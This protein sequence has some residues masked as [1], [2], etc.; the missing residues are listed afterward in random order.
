MTFRSRLTVAA[1]AAVAVAIVL[2]A[3]AIYVVVRN[4]LLGTVD[5]ALRGSV[6]RVVRVDPFGARVVE[7]PRVS[8]SV[9]FTEQ[10]VLAQLVR[11]DGVAVAST[12]RLSLPVTGRAREVASGESD[13]YFSDATLDGVHVRVY[14]A[15]L[16][17]GVAL[18]VVRP[19]EELDDVLARLRWI[20]V[21]IAACGVALAA[22]LGWVVARAALAPVRRLTEAAEH[23]SSTA[24]LAR[25][26]DASGSDELARLAGRF[27]TMLAA[28]EGSMHAQRRLVADASHE[29][30]TPI[31]TVRTNLEVLARSDG[32]SADERARVL[33]DVV[34]QLEELS[35][36]VS[37]LVELARHGEPRL[38]VED[39][40]VDELVARAVERVGAR[41]PAVTFDTRLE[42]WTA[43]GV[44]ERLERAVANLLDNAVKWSPPG[45][46]V[47]VVT[48]P[49][50][51]VVRDHGPGVDDA[52]APRVFD[53]FYRA[54]GARG[55]PGSGLGLAIVRH[56]AESHGGGA[57]VEAAEGGGARFRLRVP[58]AGADAPSR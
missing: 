23:V 48:A 32:L 2:A 42:P 37:D 57:S 49:G 13:A 56:V 46:V 30:R 8:S 39:V 10:I 22:G 20:L 45:G 58:A 6:P 24:D 12:Q 53:R 21:V 5:A 50:E 27:N 18:Q 26:I 47:E 41:A 36:L 44:P 3:V 17:P 54:P 19:V 31:T 11:A 55:L 35:V 51:I 4:E 34:A 29:L 16:E 43:R 1:A 52:D 40:R 33:D 28:L 7:P 15:Q 38:D 14:T 9:A 25:R